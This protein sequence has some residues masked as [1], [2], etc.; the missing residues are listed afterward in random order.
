M[1]SMRTDELELVTI[2]P[3]LAIYISEKLDF[4]LDQLPFSKRVGIGKRKIKSND[5]LHVNMRYVGIACVG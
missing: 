2:S 5:Q 4:Y 3:L 1:R